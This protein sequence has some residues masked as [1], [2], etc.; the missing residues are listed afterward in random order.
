[1]RSHFLFVIL[2]LLTFVMWFGTVDAYV[3]PFAQTSTNE[4]PW[5][6]KKK[7]N[8]ENYEFIDHNGRTNLFRRPIGG[9]TENL[10]VNTAYNAISAVVTPDLTILSYTVRGAYIDR[11]WTIDNVAPA[12]YDLVNG[13]WYGDMT[14][15][16]KTALWVA[17]TNSVEQAK[18][19]E[20]DRI[21]G[22]AKFDVSRTPEEYEAYLLAGREKEDLAPGEY[23]AIARELRIYKS[24]WT[25]IHDPEHWEMTPKLPQFNRSHI[26]EQTKLKRANRSRGL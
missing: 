15:G 2:L 7:L 19:A 17:Y 20:N 18:I 6:V 16:E 22:P 21:Y 5:W 26:S 3:R 10:K 14:D 9:G 23:R 12:T 4:V 25:R 11:G 8:V 1:M 24:E 13:K